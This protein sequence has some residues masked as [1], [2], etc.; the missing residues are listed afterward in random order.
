MRFKKRERHPV[1]ELTPRMASAY[2]R[3]CKRKQEKLPLFAEIIAEA[4]PSWETES[5][6]RRSANERWDQ[7]ARDDRAAKWR[8]VR[9]RLFALPPHARKAVL[10]RYNASRW[11]PREPG[12][13]TSTIWRSMVPVVVTAD[14][15][16][17]PPDAT[18]LIAALNDRARNGD[19]FTRCREA[20]SPGVM[21]FLC[22]NFTADEEYDRPC[23]YLHTVH[24][25]KLGLYDRVAKH[26]DWG[27]NSDPSGCRST[28][29]FEFLGRAFR[30]EVITLAHGDNTPSAAPWNSDLSRRVVWIGLE[31]EAVDLPVA[32]FGYG[33]V[34]DTSAVDRQTF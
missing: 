24:G 8:A 9:K 28:G 33:W 32:T 25:W 3:S 17:P 13:L 7:K 2:A 29:F 4:Q 6:R 31:D 21:A 1:R 18:A 10:D 27:S 12:F 5:A 14:D 23:L 22:P 11:Y 15:V 34:P 19:T 16:T 26:D 30:F 20:Y